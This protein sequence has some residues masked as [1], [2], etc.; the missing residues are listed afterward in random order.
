MFS[1]PECMGVQGLAEQLRATQLTGQ[2]LEPDLKAGET[3]LLVDGR[4][5][6]YWVWRA[7]CDAAPAGGWLSL[8]DLVSGFEDALQPLIARWPRVTVVM[9]GWEAGK[10]ACQRRR[11]AS[12]VRA[13]DKAASL[14]VS[15]QAESAR[16]I[17][18]ACLPSGA[19]MA[20][21]GRLR[22][23]CRRR[24]NL[25]FVLASGEADP[26]I[27]HRCQRLAASGMRGAVL[28]PDTDFAV[29]PPVARVFDLATLASS[30][31]PTA[32]TWSG[33]RLRAR[34]RLGPAQTALV[35][36]LTGT[37][38]FDAAG[39]GLHARI[40]EREEHLLRLA[41]A[42][43]SPGGGGGE[44]ASPAAWLLEVETAFA[45]AK[46]SD[47]AGQGRVLA[48]ALGALRRGGP[49]LPAVIA[50][51]RAGTREPP[52]SFLPREASA[53]VAAQACSWLV[54]GGR[55]GPFAHA[56]LHDSTA[57]ELSTAQRGAALSASQRKRWSASR[58][59]GALREAHALFAA[60]EGYL[61][62][63]AKGSHSPAVPLP[64]A[65]GQWSAALQ[66][67][68]TV[69]GAAACDAPPP[70]PTAAA[71]AV[72]LG[73][74][75]SVAAGA[76]A[77]DVD[78]TVGRDSA[79]AQ[80]VRC[81]LRAEAEALREYCD[82]KAPTPP[83]PRSVALCA[84]SEP[85][86]EAGPALAASLCPADAAGRSLAAL[87]SSVARGSIPEGL[88]AGA[89]EAREAVALC[90]LGWQ[91]AAW[92]RA[93]WCAE[94]GGDCEDRPLGIGVGHAALSRLVSGTASGDAGSAGS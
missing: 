62:P 34:L 52:S 44:G 41:Q 23:L 65:V 73:L 31:P 14:L 29:F 11:L 63:A 25:G 18:G 38:V 81:G 58:A 4:A 22:E 64:W 21:H 60:V 37:D 57:G 16:S 40:G 66:A 88:C 54:L 42:P 87:L 39:R 56:L 84:G 26:C 47:A 28:S 8:A 61:S 55:A 94:S 86:G 72:P 90:D 74:L 35:A 20:L 75:A 9:D 24:P 89:R 6:A 93:V 17:F 68:A 15:G 92:A 32:C 27:A 2:P 49:A 78:A 33:Q 77:C 69:Q 53:C 3:E 91:V 67:S 19:W 10:A 46:V 30:P 45:A 43:S 50:A 1:F 79:P 80:A 48:R 13:R 12:R 36:C 71:A 76:W 70:A 85:E 5:F 59:E 83:R 51:V 82:G 7:L